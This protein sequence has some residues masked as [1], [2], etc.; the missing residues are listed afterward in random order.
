MPGVIRRNVAVQTSVLSLD[1]IEQQAADILDRAEK[2]ANERC[3][4]L[5][6]QAETTIESE[7]Q[8]GF[9]QGLENGRKAGL[10]ETRAA[11]NAAIEQARKEAKANIVGLTQALQAALGEINDR[12]HRL[13]AEAE[14]GLIQLSLAI[15]GRVCGGIAQQSPQPAIDA[16]RRLLD[17]VR[18]SHDVELQVNPS[19]LELLKAVASEFVSQSDALEHVRVTAN[20]EVSRGGAILIGADGNIDA[21][22][23]TQLDRIASALLDQSE[24]RKPAS[25][26]AETI[27]VPP[28]DDSTANESASPNEETSNG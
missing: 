15:A 5:L 28:A 16:T 12:R 3:R 2:T 26:V 18:H 11:A 20:S 6:K 22:V 21:T 23:E 25:P 24:N 19:E 13:Y 1:N 9:Q 8:R 27:P 17:L 14:R 7:R 10:D 4:E